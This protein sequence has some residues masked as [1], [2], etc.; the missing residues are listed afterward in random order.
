MR[1]EPT[2][3]APPALAEGAVPTRPGWVF[4]LWLAGVSG[5]LL[6]DAVM[7]FALGW[8]ASASGGALAGA[9][10]TCI[11]VP[12]SIFLLLGGAVADRY[13]ARRVMLTGDAVM[14]AVTLIAA[15]IWVSGHH[16]PWLLL[17][18]GLCIGTVEA[19]YLPASG[20]MPRRLVPDRAVPQAMAA[21]Q[22]VGRVVVLAGAPLGGVLVAAAGLSAALV[23]DV[24][25]FAVMLVVMSAIRV[26]GGA[27]SSAAG[28]LLAEMGEGIRAAYRD[29]LLRAALILVGAVAGFLIP[30]GSLMVPLLARDAGWGPTS[31]GLVTGA[32]GGLSV[33]VAVV[34]MSV[35]T[36]RRAG[37]LS[38][39]GLLIAGLGVLALALSDVLALSVAAS[40]V[41]G[42]GTG[43]FATHVGPLVLRTAAAGQM[44]RIQSIL[45]L[46]Q[47]VPLIVTNNVLGSLADRAGAGWAAGL[48]A[49]LI[50]ATGTYGILN[51]PLRTAVF[52]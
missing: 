27:P 32:F 22:V 18:L 28:N 49:V 38:A 46:V 37:L 7:Y 29:P 35:G 8:V 14:L 30:I 3:P 16:S 42:L 6:G 15:G 47:T 34:A 1:A 31:A 41:A 2:H 40:A 5:T 4:W 51:R 12:R 43:L 21:R 45:V 50:I 20:S 23:F 33:L 24:L 11:A 52:D 10:L 39:T 9:V 44:S 26:P 17:V 13:G 19:F 36:H 25:T 48:C